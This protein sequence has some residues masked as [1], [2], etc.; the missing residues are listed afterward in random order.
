MAVVAVVGLGV[1]CTSSGTSGPGSSGATRGT[2]QDAPHATQLPDPQG[3]EGVDTVVLE[4]PAQQA[5]SHDRFVTST[6][7][8]LC[9]SNSTAAT[10]MRDEENRAIG[11]FNL[12]QSS[13][14]ANAARDPFWRAMVSAE[15]AQT[16][17]ATA[18]IEATCMR[19]HAPMASEAAHAANRE[20]NLADLYTLTPQAQLISDGVSCSVCHQV[21]ADNLGTPESYSG[22][23]EIGTER[24]IWGPHRNPATAPMRNHVNY[25]PTFS[26]H[27]TT[28]NLCATCHNLATHTLSADGTEVAGSVFQ[29]Q[30]TQLEWQNSAYNDAE[31]EDGRT[32]QSCHMPTTSVDGAPLRTRIAR[33][34]PGGDFNIPERDPFGR[35]VFAGANTLM[36]AIIQANRN[37]LNPQAPD[38]AFEATVAEARQRLERDTATVTLTGVAFENGRLTAAVTV[39][40]HAGHRFPT[41]FPSRRAWLRVTVKDA[42]GAVLFESGGFNAR[43]RLVDQDGAVLDV[44]KAGG[45][46]EPHH[47]TLTRSDQ[48]QVYEQVMA[49]A[50]GSRTSSL[51]RA[52]TQLKDNRILP[53]GYRADHPQ[54]PLGAPVGVGTDADFTAGSD[55]VHVEVPLQGTPAR[56]EAALFYQVL[57][58]RFATDLF[59]VDTLEVRAFRTMVDAADMTP[60]Q[61]GS[62]SVD[63]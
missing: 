4:A 36:P 53:R 14:M 32:C 45:P 34:P 52:S 33:S 20:P 50:D 25:T 23:F 13:M 40:S 7:C 29:E 48:V 12:W 51:L 6:G 55:R 63:L 3:V 41:G 9:H 56:V 47:P 44:E 61:V 21:K 37:V 39:E 31:H 10:A 57:G 35:H 8:A 46:H 30:A 18:A 54:A 26:L 15:S 42:A 28:A 43:G 58:A 24:L 27:V 11:P 2:P 16:P 1:A 49:S 17:N 62:A 38:A 5:V 22:G 19:C 60:V 59:Q